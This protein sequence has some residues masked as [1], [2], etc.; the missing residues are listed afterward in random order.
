MQKNY[1]C[2]RQARQYC[3]QIIS[4]F[5][6]GIFSLLLCSCGYHLRSINMLP[7]ALHRL[8]LTSRVPYD[9]F[10]K[11]LKVA[12]LRANL[13]LVK[14]KTLA[15]YTLNITN[16]SFYKTSPSLAIS[17]STQLSTVTLYYRVY[18]EILDNHGKV[19]IPQTLIMSYRTITANANQLLGTTNEINNAKQEMIQELIGNLINELGSVHAHQALTKNSH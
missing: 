17:L 16:I 15:P 8:Y 14:N 2:A 18:Y 11:Q 1:Y 7:K 4:L 3:R 10:T 5:I 19:V 13:T 6:I 12:L 9:P